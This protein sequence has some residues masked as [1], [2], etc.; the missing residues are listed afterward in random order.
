VEGVYSKVALVGSPTAPPPPARVP[1]AAVFEPGTSDGVIS[2][3]GVRVGALICADGGFPN[4]YEDRR[5][6]GVQLFTHASGS[7]GLK[8]APTNPMPDEAAR[9]YQRPVVFANQR[10]RDRFGHGNSQICDARG[11]VLAQAGAEPNAIIDAIVDV[12]PV[13]APAADH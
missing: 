13:D 12:P 7:M 5:V 1:E 8:T 2:W 3:G 9:R 10:R 4:F 11:T 6:K